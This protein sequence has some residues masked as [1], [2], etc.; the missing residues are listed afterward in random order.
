[1]IVQGLIAIQEEQVSV[2]CRKIDEPAVKQALKLAEDLFKKAVTDACGFTPVLEP[3]TI[4]TEN[5]LPGPFAEG[6]VEYCLGG[7]DL[8]ARKGKIVSNNTIDA[9]LA[10]VFKHN[11]PHTRAFLFG[12]VA[13]R[14]KGDGK[15]PPHLLHY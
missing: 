12:E 15:L 14:G 5:Y 9:R 13:S 6:A 10:Q 11:L 2:R 4:D 1:L 7:V 3:L 8:V